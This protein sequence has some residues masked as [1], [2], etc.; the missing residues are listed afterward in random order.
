MALFTLLALT[1]LSLAFVAL[2]QTEP[3]IA[4]NHL[5]ASQA[6]A[7]AE[8]GIERAVWALTNAL[9]PGAIGGSGV[10]PNVVPA[11]SAPPPYDGSTFLPVGRTGG[12]RITVTGTAP[13]I[14]TVR[15]LG[16]SGPE[17]ARRTSGGSQI[18]ATLARLRNLAFEAPCALCVNASLAIASSVIDARGSEASNCGG[19]VAAWSTSDVTF[20]GTSTSLYGA[21]APAGTPSPEEATGSGIRAAGTSC[22]RP[23]SST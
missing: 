19:K 10:P 14:R 9:E 16:W 12:V 22:S 15:A 5:R 23:P 1:T 13:S 2:A 11:T 18:V 20:D 17:A 6:H 21:A 3:A 7:M 4:V 8:S